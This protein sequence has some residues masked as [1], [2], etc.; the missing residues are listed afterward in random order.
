MEQPDTFPAAG[1]F[2]IPEWRLNTVENNEIRGVDQWDVT[3]G[4][5]IKQKKVNGGKKRNGLGSEDYFLKEMY[6]YSARM[7]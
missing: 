4:G 7:H 1:T 5:A 6:T 3:V 2:C